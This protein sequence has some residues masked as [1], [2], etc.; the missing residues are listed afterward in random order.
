MKRDVHDTL[1]A[2]FTT[3]SIVRQLHDVPPHEVYEVF[4]DGQRAVYKGNTGPTGKATLEGH[5]IAF[6]GDQTSVPVPEILLVGD[7]YYVAA[8]HPNAPAPD[9]G[10]QADET[11]AYAAGRGLATLHNET[12]P[13]IDRYGR[14][15]PSV[16]GT[17]VAEDD[18]W[19]AAALAYVHQYR[20]TLAQHGHADVADMVLEFLKDHPSVFSGADGPVC[21][22]GW[23]TPEHVTVV[24][25]QVAC[26]VDFEHAIAAPGEFDYWRTG[27][28]TF[29]RDCDASGEAFRAGYESVRS[30]S[31]GFERRK[32]LYTILNGVYYFESLYVQDQHGPEETREHAQKLR[33]GVLEAVEQV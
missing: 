12:D 19:H 11:W 31:S 6:V 15:R 33:D 1:A 27:L 8:W 20:P 16:N 26:M 3:H 4:V 23:A 9:E 14:F 10:G 30:L 25:E 2:Q 24:D 17:V 13:L 7:G 18:D 5:V 28:P 29:G 21:C 32:P 22:H